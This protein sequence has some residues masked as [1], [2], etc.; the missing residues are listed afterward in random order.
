MKESELYVVKEDKFNNP[1]LSDID[2]IIDNCDEH[3]HN[4]HFHIYN[5]IMTLKLILLI[6]LIMKIFI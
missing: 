3:F 6:L 4:K 1:N 5:L 2:F